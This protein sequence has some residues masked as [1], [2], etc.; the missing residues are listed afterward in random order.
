MSTILFS[1]FIRPL[2]RF[3]VVSTGTM[4]QMSTAP[5]LM[6]NRNK[7]RS[8]GDRGPEKNYEKKMAKKANKPLVNGLKD[9]E[10]QPDASNTN[11]PM[12]MLMK[13]LKDLEVSGYDAAHEI[14]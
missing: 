5:C 11:Q 6:T 1:E 3:Y 13:G 10:S 12:H 14:Q 7:P 4:T 8:S 9:T 2:L